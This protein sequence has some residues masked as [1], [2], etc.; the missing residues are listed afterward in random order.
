MA[1]KPGV[2]TSYK[3]ECMEGVH[4]RDDEYC[5]ALYSEAAELSTE[6]RKY[7]P[8]N[9]ARGMGYKPGGMPLTGFRVTTDNGVAILTFN[10]PRW[11]LV[12]ATAHGALIYNRSQANRAVAVVCFG[13]VISATNGPFELNFPLP[14]AQTGL[15]RIK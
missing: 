4:S 10:A 8:N 9:E 13:E 11:V 12:T 14:T 5:L 15:I 3:A 2:C 1:I 7:I 6:T